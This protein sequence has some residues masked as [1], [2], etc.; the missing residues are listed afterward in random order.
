MWGLDGDEIIGL[1]VSNSTASSGIR[2]EGWLIRLEDD[3]GF[4]I[5]EDNSGFVIQEQAP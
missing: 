5:L 2:P 1:K 4:V 3:S